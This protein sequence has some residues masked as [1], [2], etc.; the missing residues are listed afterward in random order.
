MSTSRGKNID[1]D[2]FNAPLTHAHPL[3]AFFRKKYSLF[4]KTSSMFSIDTVSI[5]IRICVDKLSST[6][7]MYTE[8]NE[9]FLR[10]TT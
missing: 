6:T 1:R 5:K 7:S 4:L 9:T 2:T 8:Q 10:E 3:N